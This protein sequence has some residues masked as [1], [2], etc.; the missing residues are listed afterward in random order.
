MKVL[1]TGHRGYIGAVLTPMLHE[2]GHD[3][4]GLDSDIFRSC[5]FSGALV[6]TPTREEDV[7]DVVVDDLAGFD[8]VIHLA[9]LS[10]DPLGDYRPNLTQQI[11][12]EASVNLAQ[13][14]KKAGVPRFLFAS[15]CSNYGAA[16]SDFLS[17]SAAFNPVTPYGVSK[18]DVE[19][20]VAPMADESFSPTFLRAS[21]AYGL[22][23][24]IRFDLVLNN[25]TA[26]AFTTGQIYLKSDGSPWRPIVHVEDIA[27]AY[28]AALEADR[29]LVH[30]EAFNVGLTTENY[31]VREIADIVQAIVPNSRI[32]FAPGAGPDTRCYRVD[33]NFIGRRLHAF[34][35]Q[36]TARRG[37]EQLYEAFCSIGLSLE[38]FEGERF[39]RIAHVKKLIRDGDLDEDLR[40]VCVPAMAVAV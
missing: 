3:V 28:I 31:Q 29:E 16:G 18:V 26:W 25:L 35:P 11:N 39:K 23:P 13:L 27:R 14:A 12:C 21:T 30:N 40:R 24:R 36:W 20:A 22:S 5:T 33:C 7:R 38:D 8:A 34:K 37:V 4:T 1:V 10:N 17:E 19:H 9:G 6:E 2:R 32:E 15:S